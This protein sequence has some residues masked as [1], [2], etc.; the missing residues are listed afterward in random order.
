MS[1]ATTSLAAILLDLPPVIHPIVCILIGTITGTAVVMIPAVLKVKWGANELVSSLMLNY[2]CLYMATYLIR[3][4]VMDT[5]LGVTASVTFQ[6]TASLPGHCAGYAA[7]PG[8]C[9]RG[10]GLRAVLA[11]DVPY[12]AGL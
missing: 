5:S 3:T 7:A 8:A 12:K 2:I 4:K 1:C 6:P 9:V 10:A 11:D